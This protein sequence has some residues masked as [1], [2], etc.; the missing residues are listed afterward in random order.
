MK[1]KLIKNVN[2]YSTEQDKK[3]YIL[4]W[5]KG[6][7]FSFLK[8]RIQSD[9]ENAFKTADNILK[10]LQSIYEDQNKERTAYR[11]FNKLFQRIKF[12][13]LFYAEFWR[14]AAVLHYEEMHLINDLWDKISYVMQNQIVSQ[15]YIKLNDMTADCIMINVNLQNQNA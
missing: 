13:Q 8:L 15:W 10:A 1:N 5:V 4:I 3:I 14:L 2:Y 7:I 12:F 9:A 11:E 6:Q